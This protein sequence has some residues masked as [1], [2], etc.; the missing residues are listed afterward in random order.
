M[1]LVSLFWEN[2]LGSAR[3]GEFLDAAS[4]GTRARG[5]ETTDKA[6]EKLHKS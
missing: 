3:I 6:L 5:Y 4:L 2:N 1:Q